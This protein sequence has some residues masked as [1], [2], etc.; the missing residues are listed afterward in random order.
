MKTKLKMFLLAVATAA[1]LAAPA[2]AKQVRNLNA[3]PSTVPGNARASI[4]PNGANG[5]TSYWGSEGG[6]YTPSLPTPRY[7]KNPNFQSGGGDR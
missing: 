6:P 3:A 2:M 5:F 1:L 4:L 7:G